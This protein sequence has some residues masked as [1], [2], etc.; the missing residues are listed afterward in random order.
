MAWLE[1]SSQMTRYAEF[2]AGEAVDPTLT[3]CLLLLIA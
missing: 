1:S 2:S 3:E